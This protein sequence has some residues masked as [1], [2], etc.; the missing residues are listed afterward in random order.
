MTPHTANT[1]LKE[2]MYEEV[3]CTVVLSVKTGSKRKK[4]KTLIGYDKARLHPPVPGMTE[5]EC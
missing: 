1:P 5:E 2:T 4:K 3:G